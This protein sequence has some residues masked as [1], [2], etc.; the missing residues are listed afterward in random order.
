[1]TTSLS[2]RV[3]LCVA[4]RALSGTI[5]W[6]TP[7]M[8][9][10]AFTCAWFQASC[11]MLLKAWQNTSPEYGSEATKKYALLT[12]PVTVSTTCMVGPAQSTNIALPGSCCS[13]ATTSL[14]AAN[15]LNSSQYCE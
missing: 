11:F 2:D 6:G 12:S 7:P 1:M 13:V 4:V 15:R 10:S 3:R 14:T 9:A 8:N 5:S